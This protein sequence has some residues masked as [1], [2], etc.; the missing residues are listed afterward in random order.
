MNDTRPPA[1]CTATPAQSMDACRDALARK[2]Q[3][4][5][6]RVSFGDSPRS[7]LASREPAQPQPPSSP[8]I[9]GGQIA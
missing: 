6:D 9:I 3:H 8:R 1:H 5:G 4:S 7:P 2:A